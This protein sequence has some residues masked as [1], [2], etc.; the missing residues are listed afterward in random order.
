M[1]DT[2]LVARSNAVD[3]WETIYDST[4]KRKS[5]SAEPT[6]TGTCSTQEII[7]DGL[8]VIRASYLR[9]GLSH[10]AVTTIMQSWRDSTASQ[11]KPYIDLWVSFAS[12]RCSYLT[13]PAKDVVEFLCELQSKKFTYNQICMARSAVS[14]VVSA[15]TNISMGRHPLVKRFMKGLF[16]LNPQFPR[17]KFVWDVSILFRYLKML[18]EPKNLSL[19][20][21]G[22]K[23]A[24]LICLVAGGQ[25]CQTVHAINVLHIRLVNGVCYIPL[26]TKLK[27]TRIGHHLAPLKFKVFKDPKL[28]VITNLTEYLKRTHEKRVDGALF[29]SYYRPHKKVSK[30]TISRWVK[31]M[32]T[33]TGID[34]NFV[35]HSSRSAAS[36]FARSNI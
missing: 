34:G 14:S 6:K 12:Q 9:Q 35:S 21:L 25:R 33:N 24:I 4:R 7:P 16:E 1:A 2:G 30:D 28:C 27:Q 29:I 36:S 11:Y 26:Y 8:S 19:N 10:A 3:G 23:L 15:G 17:Y 22:K 5:S 31:E 20:L 32:M 13:P 18:D